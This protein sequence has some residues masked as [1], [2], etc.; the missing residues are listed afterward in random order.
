[1]VFPC[2]PCRRLGGARQVV[3]VTGASG[4]IASWLVK[5]LLECGY[6]VKATVRDTNDPEKV[7][8]LLNLD[9]ANE[10]LHLVKANL[11][12]E[13]SFDSTVE[14]CHAVFH[15]ASPFFNDAKDPQT[16]LLDL[17]MKGT[18]NVLK[19]YDPEKVDHFLSLD[20]ANERLH[21][22]KANLLE[23]GSFDSTVEGCHAVFHTAS[24]FFN[25]V[26]DLQTELLD[27][28]MKGTLNVLKSS[29][30]IM[31]F[32]EE[33]EA[34]IIHCDIKPQNILVDEFWT[35]KISDFGLAK[36]LMPDQ[37]RTMTGARGTRGYLAPE[38]NKNGPISVKTDVYRYRIMLLEILCCRRNI[39]V[40]APEPEAV[41]LCSWA[42][43]Y[44]VAGKLN[45]I[46][47]W[48]V[49]D[50]KT[51]VE[52]MVK[53]TAARAL[54]MQELHKQTKPDFE[55][56]GRSASYP[57]DNARYNELTP[58]LLDDA[59]SDDMPNQTY[60][61]RTTSFSARTDYE[62]DKYMVE[63]SGTH[64][65]DKSV[66]EE[67]SIIKTDNKDPKCGRPSQIIIKDYDE[68]DDEWPEEDSDLG[69][70]GGTTL[71]IVNEEDISFSDLE[72]DDY[73]IKPVT[74]STGGLKLV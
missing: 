48:E 38:W 68:D 7:D 72:D 32:H 53:I 23:E 19:S 43:N 9:D 15:T 6:T 63:T 12:E 56:F 30:E 64:L 18:L 20:G 58:S 29:V 40:H 33:C 70:Y 34:S 67:K 37:T 24:P 42:Y 11:L 26:K 14:G 59:Y 35:A 8:H 47:P 51:A 36:L 44:F 73:G 71:P 50:D 27:L 25:D 54:W 52:N 62:T 1:M 31:Y 74:L 60:G 17:A 16:E 46:F 13:G 55:I 5:F 61:Y 22:V 39:E 28:A 41:S 21:L 69:E 10:R 4:Y 65:T 45:K 57:K 2:S 49:V 3:C 66:I